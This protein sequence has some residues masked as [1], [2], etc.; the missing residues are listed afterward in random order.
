MH[1]KGYLHRDI[2]PENFL[3]GTGTAA[4]TVHIIDFG[5]AKSYVDPK[6][7]KHVPYRDHDGKK[8]TGT[9]RYASIKAH[10]GIEQSRRDDLFSL[11]YVLVF[12]T[13]GS[14][15]W[16]GAKGKTRKERFENVRDLKQAMTFGAL[17]RNLPEEFGRY[18]EICYKLSFD[19]KPDYAN[20]R[21]LFRDLL[22]KQKDSEDLRFDWEMAVASP[23]A[24]A[25]KE[26]EEKKKDSAKAED[27]KKSPEVPQ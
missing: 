3:L 24:G 4:H 15:P 27:G 11:G 25:K 16:F 13:A 10:M 9:A 22:L 18:L 2:K 12:L 14:L 26:E 7:G 21:K 23:P 20:L 17:C 1:S 6:S 5:L 8:L 19:A